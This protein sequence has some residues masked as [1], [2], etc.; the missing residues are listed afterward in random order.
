LIH[1]SAGNLRLN[2]YIAKKVKRSIGVLSKL[3]YFVSTNTL[4]T[5]HVLCYMVYPF[6]IFSIISWGNTYSSTIQ[7]LF[8]LQKRAIRIM[9]FS[10]CDE[11]SSPIFKS[12]KIIKL[13]DTL[14]IVIFMSKFHHQSY[15]LPL[16]CFLRQWKMS[17]IIIHVHWIHSLT[18]SQ[19]YT[20]KIT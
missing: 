12:L 10:K 11:H 19:K 6:L 4:I 15:L 8:V 9:T 2:M 14:Y 20:G 17:L 18:I 3:R 13:C 5:M 7:P 1:I 16:N